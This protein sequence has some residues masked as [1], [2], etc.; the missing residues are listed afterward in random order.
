LGLIKRRKKLWAREAQGENQ[1]Q[2]FG[3]GKPSS[4]SVKGEPGQR[5]LDD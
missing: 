1:D 4:I 3:I 2:Q 5:A